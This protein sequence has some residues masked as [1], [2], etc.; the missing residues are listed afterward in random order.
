MAEE[1]RADYEQLKSV[2]ERFSRQSESVTQMMR[3]VQGSMNKLK[4]GWIGRGSDAFFTEMS[5]E[6]LPAVGRLKQALGEA[7]TTTQKISNTV[8]QAEQEASA[9]FR[10]AGVV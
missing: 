4:D 1:I 2:A 10:A 3:S 5:D 9:P 7:S 8:K 6:V